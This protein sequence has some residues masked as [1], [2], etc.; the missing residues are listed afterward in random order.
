M[1]PILDRQERPDCDDVIIIDKRGAVLEASTA[2][3]FLVKDKTLIT[4]EDGV[5]LPGVMRNHIC[6]IA[7]SLAFTI[8]KKR[9]VMVDELES[10]DEI[11][12]TNSLYG[13]QPVRAVD[14]HIFLSLYF[15]SD[16]QKKFLTESF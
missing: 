2:N 13:V 15:L 3:I 11:F 8:E 10:C 16:S 4:P 6:D 14:D 12:L 1:K 5:I 7:P 9:R